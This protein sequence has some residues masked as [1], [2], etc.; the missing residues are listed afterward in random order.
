MN[1][2][3][4]HFSHLPEKNISQRNFIIRGCE[5]LNTNSMKIALSQSDLATYNSIPK[6][7]FLHFV[8]VPVF[9]QE[10]TK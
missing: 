10:N 4:I 6:Q 1:L 3:A 7:F 8:D 9:G 2:A 5:R